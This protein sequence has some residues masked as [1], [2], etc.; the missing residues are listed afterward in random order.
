MKAEL[1]IKTI[2][3]YTAENGD[4]KLILTAPQ[5]QRG[6][7][8]ALM[9]KYRKDKEKD[10]ERLYG[11]EIAPYNPK[12]SYEANSYFWVLCDK[13]AK[14]LK[15]TKEEIYRKAIREVGQFEIV[16]IKDLAVDTYIKRWSKNGLG[17][18]A[19]TQE[20]SKITG[21]TRVVTYFGSSSYNRSEM[22]RIIEYL[23]DECRELGIE[24]ITPEEKAKM[25]A[26]IKE[27]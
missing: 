5:A 3:Q 16:P 17:W 12:R 21:Y 13:V 8:S 10:T 2:E 27:E 9:D 4:I 20:G 11:A 15:S 22:T 24:T 26:H 1:I 23:I 6:A 14:A 18:F 25:L 7:I 19:E